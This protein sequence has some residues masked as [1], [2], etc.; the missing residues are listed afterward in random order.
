MA[1]SK[2]LPYRVTFGFRQFLQPLPHGLSPFS[3]SEKDQR[4][5]LWRWLFRH[6]LPFL[7]LL[8]YMYHKLCIPGDIPAAGDA[9]ADIKISQH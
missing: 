2:G 7:H 5:F 4:D 1:P 3:G 9:C 6:S 8:S